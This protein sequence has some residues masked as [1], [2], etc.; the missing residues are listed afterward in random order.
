MGVERM[1]SNGETSGFFQKMAKL[2]FYHSKLR[3][4]P[5]LL[6]IAKKFV[7]HH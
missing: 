5:F 7:S 3:K 4:E 2:V 6:K 1:F